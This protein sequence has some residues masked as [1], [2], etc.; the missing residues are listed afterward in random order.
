VKN[1]RLRVLITA[2]SLAVLAAACSTSETAS[3]GGIDAL[4]VRISPVD[5]AHTAL[6]GFEFP[7]DS[8]NIRAGLFDAKGVQVESSGVTWAL[9]FPTGQ[10]VADS[11][12]SIKSTGPN[13]ATIYFKRETLI[14]AVATVST[15][16]G[17]S[18]TGTLYIAWK[19]Q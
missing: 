6:N 16:S 18:K 7:P 19:P 17:E 4:E 12:A 10:S 14:G 1:S 11:I 9:Q 2:A 5:P 13:T 15:S 3:P 8:F